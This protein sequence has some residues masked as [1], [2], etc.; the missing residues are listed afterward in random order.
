MK[1]SFE[2]LISLFTVVCVLLSGMLFAIGEMLLKH[3]L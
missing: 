2:R 1:S 3:C